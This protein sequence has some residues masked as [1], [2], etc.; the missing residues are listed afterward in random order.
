MIDFRRPGASAGQ[1]ERELGRLPAELINRLHHR[2]EAELLRHRVPVE[3]DH[4]ERLGYAYADP[5][6]LGQHAHRQLV[7]LDHQSG[8]HRRRP[9][10]FGDDHAPLIALARGDDPLSGC[11]DPRFRH[12]LAVAG[13]SI[14]GAGMG[15]GRVGPADEGD[16]PVSEAEQVPGG[17]RRAGRVIDRHSGSA[18]NPLVD[19]DERHPELAQSVALSGGQLQ[20]GDDQC[21]GV[22]PG[23]QG[24]EELVALGRVEGAIDQEF[25]TGL[26]QRRVHAVEQGAVEPPAER[27]AD[28][29]GNPVE[30][31]G[32][33]AR[34]GPGDRER[35][36][37]RRGPHPGSGLR[38]HQVRAAQGPGDGRDRYAGQAGHVLHARLSHGS[39]D[40][41]S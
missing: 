20:R 25:L 38:R 7:G 3:P 36:F 9:D 40:G 13:Q 18:A 10:E 41:S 35:E 30:L 8:R 12:H 15:A 6:Q 11:G 21:V 1:R 19:V 27:S 23:R 4:R 34:C 29:D 17:A 24:G 5:G 31:A 2:A 14:Q 33:E 26:V 32:R 37:S 39:A 16:P 28:Q 22:A